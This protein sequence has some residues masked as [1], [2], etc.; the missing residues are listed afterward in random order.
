MNI[1][2]RLGFTHSSVFYLSA[3]GLV[4]CLLLGGG[5]RSGFLSDAVL[6]L[7][8]IPTLLVALWS[9]PYVTACRVTWWALA[10]CLA[11]VVI[12]LV[13]LIPLP[14][15]IWA[16]LPNREPS[17][18]AFELLGRSLPWLPISVSPKSTWLAV[19]ALI[20]PV[21][22]F[23]GT[24]QLSYR[25]RRQLSLIVLAVG[26]VSVFIGLMQVAQGQASPLRFYEFTNLNDAV[27]FFANR[28]H[29]AALL[30]CLTL[31]AA[32]WAF[33]FAGT[34]EAPS[35]RRRFE[36]TA[37]VPLAASFTALVVLVAAQTTARSRAGIFLTIVALL[38]AFALAYPD[39]HRRSASV[40]GR[41]LFGA[42]TVAMVLGAQF[43]LYRILDR[44]G[45]D[46]LA[47]ARIPFARNTIA[48]AK[49]YLPFGSGMGTF[50]PVYGLFETPKDALANTFANRA[51]NDF[52][53]LW[54]E[55]GVVGLLL[56][57]LFALW[58]VSRTIAV[59]RT[60]PQNGRGI[61]HALAR[62]ATLIVA[63]LIAHSFVDYPLRTGA[64]MAM[65][66]FAAALL[67]PPPAEA[68]REDEVG[69]AHRREPHRTEH[70]HSS[71]EPSRRP[72][73]LVSWPSSAP[74]AKAG[75]APSPASSIGARHDEP[76]EWP[77]A[78]RKPQQSSSAGK[79]KPGKK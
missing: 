18:A 55:T 24:L 21:A 70:R 36:T 79:T 20:P 62:A 53:E 68:E 10:F 7:I 1:R 52:L 58:L 69:S 35:V 59:W 37:I 43:S 33:G 65:F 32:A 57:G 3:V 27:G 15:R 56:M 72:T 38:G 9:L 42:V 61:D 75:A 19:L 40:S 16:D 50:V 45:A 12:P 64:L 28:N 67:I 23:L 2:E 76:I 22:V 4:S 49:T 60:A 6:Q 29:F 71:I 73:H 44:F 31:L 74:E 30:Y 14:P 17:V 39:R 78:W 66:A 25:K 5:T 47:D 54:L 11:L 77:E 26:I 13:Q 8:A 48:A 63:L 34:P 46:P 51:H 41:M